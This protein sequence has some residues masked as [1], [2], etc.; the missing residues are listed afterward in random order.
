MRNILTSLLLVF[1]LMFVSCSKDK[2]IESGEDDTKPK[3][4]LPDDLSARLSEGKL[5]VVDP[6]IYV[7]RGGKRHGVT[8]TEER[9]LSFFKGWDKYSVNPLLLQLGV[10]F[11]RENIKIVNIELP[12]TDKYEGGDYYDYITYFT[13][14]R[15]QM[16]F[17]PTLARRSYKVTD[18]EGNLTGENIT[19]DQNKFRILLMDEGP[20][21]GYAGGTPHRALV[22]NVNG[23]TRN[24]IA[25]EVGHLFGLGHPD[26]GKSCFSDNDLKWVMR[27]VIYDESVFFN[28][29]ETEK[30]HKVLKAYATDNKYRLKDQFKTVNVDDKGF[31]SS[32]LKTAWDMIETREFRTANR[33]LQ[34]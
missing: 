3:V 13:G 7:A 10:C 26:E 6:V 8:M 23:A 32:D 1:V 18:A 22:L 5:Y 20:T 25:H 29:C 16:T 33:D 11:N 17:D 28:S 9:I 14:I 15:G 21:G 24:I 4:N 2:N 30:A 12:M 34:E 19:I 27:T 31:A